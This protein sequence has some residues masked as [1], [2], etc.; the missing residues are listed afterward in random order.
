MDAAP[1][2]YADQ[3]A[4]WNGLAGRVWVEMQ[5]LLDQMFRPLEDRLAETV[6]A[7]SD[8]AVLDVGCGTGAITLAVARRLAPG[9]CSVGVDISEPMIA[10]AKARAAREGA[11]A[12]FICAD[13]QTHPFEPAGFDMILSR[14]G[15]MFF[16]DF[17]AAFANLRRAAKDDAALRCV[18]WR[19]PEENPF[20]TTAERA[21]APFLPAMP[22][23][24]PDAPGQFALADIGR[25]RRV[26]AEGGWTDI[27]IR[28]ID[29]PCAFPESDLV[30]YFTRLGPLGL[31]LPQADERTR[32]RVVKTVRA[33]FDPY[34][35]D[36]QVRFVA[37]CWMVAARA[38]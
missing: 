21:A 37:A 10:A 19:S 28:P 36:G 17:T 8:F 22:A 7:G 26:L 9:G 13:A 38:R 31:I 27:D 6:P 1:Q 24:R 16:D 20:M 32:A 18:V 15:V 5:D 4:L 3:A 30:R 25:I 29:V 34:V 33:A 14:F 11:P 12:D 2:P 23:R 35:R